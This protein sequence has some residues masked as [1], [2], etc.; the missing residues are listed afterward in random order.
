MTIRDQAYQRKPLDV[1]II[2]AHTHITP[3]YKSGWHQPPEQT[4]LKAFIDTY[5]RLGIDCC[6]TAPHALVDAM[7]TEA[8]QAAA[9]A[10]KEYPGRIYGYISVAPFGGLSVL[11]QNLSRF[12]ANPAFVGLKFLG[13]YNGDYTDPVYRYATNFAN[14]AG[15]PL[16]CHTWADTPSLAVMREMAETHPNLHLICA[17]LGGG[18]KS[19]TLKAVQIVRQV[20]NFHLETCGSLWNEIAYEE[21]VDMIGADRIIFGTDAIN[22]GT[23][24]DFGRVAFSPLPDADKE[25]IF[26]TNYLNLLKKSQMGKI[27]RP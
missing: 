19:L 6:V 25:K 12:G 23:N 18:S 15:C 7:T 13:G 3:Y 1:F 21:L 11:K 27:T 5:D 2:D 17:H 20:P 9:D 26:A 22:L 24:F 4:T 16:L 10:A 8:N 14:E